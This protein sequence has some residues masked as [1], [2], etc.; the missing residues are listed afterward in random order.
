MAATGAVFVIDPLSVKN[1][2]P[3]QSIFADKGVRKIFHGADY[4]VR[5]LYRDFK[6]RIE[7]LFDT[8]L[9]CRFL[10]MERTSLEK[11][12][13]TYFGERL[14]K[15]YQKKDWS[16][17]PL[18]EAMLEY[19]AKDAR[20]LVPLA[21]IISRELRQK[22]RQAWVAEE[23]ELLSRVR[24][25]EGMQSPLY[26]NFKG[27]GRLKP[28][29]LALL[30]KLLRFR[31]QLAERLDKPLFKI[32]GNRPLMVIAGKAPASLEALTKSQ[33]LSARQAER[34][35]REIVGMARQIRQLPENELP[36]YPKRK[37]VR[38]RA[39]VTQRINA[40]KNW[41]EE[42]ADRLEL[43][44]ALILNKAQLFGIADANPPDMNTLRAENHLKKW[45][46]REFGREIL[47]VL[48]P[49]D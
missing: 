12:V 16:K 7:N 23:C 13:F 30:E 21:K 27:A 47:A 32:L 4:D 19:A 2:S 9:A 18:P 38:R 8:E 25:A 10:G 17:R 49:Q 36:A 45:Q 1:L 33:A 46:I 39:V 43:D 24:P 42:K 28:R 35:G 44:P 26:L 41:K 48:N 3:L 22:Q 6:I 15:K 31:M 37:A 14:D 5:S 11:V 34:F 29:N 40:L 20:Y